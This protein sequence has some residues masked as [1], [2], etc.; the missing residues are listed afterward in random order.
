M[1]PQKARIG[2]LQTETGTYCG[3]SNSTELS[4]LHAVL[5]FPK[6]GGSFLPI[7]FGTFLLVAFKEVHVAHGELTFD[8]VSLMG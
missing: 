3:R 7:A 8:A 2:K 5:L 1:G 4:L 6:H